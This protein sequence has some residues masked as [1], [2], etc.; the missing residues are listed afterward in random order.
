MKR[1]LPALL[2]A[3][4]TLSALAF[5]ACG[6]DDDDAGT[7]TSQASTSASATA[8]KTQTT[9]GSKTAAA[10]PAALTLDVSPLTKSTPT[11]TESALK[12]VELAAGTGATPKKCDA[13]TVHYTGAFTNGKVFDSSRTKGE[14]YTFILGIGSVIRGWDEALLTMKVGERRMIA[15]PSALAY[16]SQGYPPIIPPNSD[17]IFDVELLKAG[18]SNSNC[19]AN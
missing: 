18:P 1:I 8:S 15:I 10:S 11:T 9:A 2:L 3:A 13:V 6:G 16:G 12:W 5:A 17:L 7:P 14:P 4:L 19:S